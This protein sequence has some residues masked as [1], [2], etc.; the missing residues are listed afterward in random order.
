MSTY[1]WSAT[2]NKILFSFRVHDAAGVTGALFTMQRVV[3]CICY[4]ITQ[5]NASVIVV[6]VYLRTIISANGDLR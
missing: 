3:H 6:Y 5:P 2:F 4:C 1:S